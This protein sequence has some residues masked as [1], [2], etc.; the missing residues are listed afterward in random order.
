MKQIRKFKRKKEKKR[1]GSQ[2]SSG[3]LG[4]NDPGWHKSLAMARSGETWSHLTPDSSRLFALRPLSWAG[5]RDWL[6]GAER[7]RHCVAF[8]ISRE[9]REGCCPLYHV[10]PIN[11]SNS[12]L[13]CVPDTVIPGSPERAAGLRT[14][15]NAGGCSLI[16]PWEGRPESQHWLTKSLAQGLGFFGREEVTI[17]LQAPVSWPPP[18]E[19]LLYP[20]LEDSGV[21]HVGKL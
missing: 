19:E 8:P 3:T 18:K 2:A 7:G 13:F 16:V 1:K 9:I 4:E 21:K 6:A 10:S 17:C 5:L 15:N 12:L 11:R 20:S 14:N